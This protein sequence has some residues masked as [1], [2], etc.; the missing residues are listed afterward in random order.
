MNSNPETVVY[1][2]V[3]HAVYDNLM[4]QNLFPHPN[5]VSSPVSPISPILEQSSYPIP[6]Y[7]PRNSQT[8]IIQPSQIRNTSAI[9]ANQNAQ[10]I[11]SS[12]G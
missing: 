12:Q 1:K 9:Q 7:N 11:P 8:V 10:N 5:T 6:S 2:E 4:A 3:S